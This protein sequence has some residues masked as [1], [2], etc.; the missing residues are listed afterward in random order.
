M[1]ITVLQSGLLNG[2]SLKSVQFAWVGSAP[3]N[4]NLQSQFKAFMPETSPFNQAW[5]MSE[6]TCTGMHL[7]PPEQ[8]MTGA[9][10]RPLP[11]CDVKLVDDEGKDI[12]AFNIRG[13]LCMRGPIIFSGYY[14]N[15]DANENSFDDEG[16]FHTGD[17]AYCDKDTKLWYIVDRKKVCI[18]PL[19]GNVC[20]VLGINLLIFRRNSSRS[21]DFRSVRLKSKPFFMTTP[22]SSRPPSLVFR[23]LL[24]P[25][26]CHVP[27]LSV[28]VERI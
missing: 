13:E 5:G 1:V 3:L 19:Y 20:Q 14:K 8:D 22:T 10:G 6:T 17:V 24:R 23:L 9:V 21:A 26:S 28:A 4:T 18:L 12:T 16:Y 11:N 15:D 27:T 2:C 25:P 7:C